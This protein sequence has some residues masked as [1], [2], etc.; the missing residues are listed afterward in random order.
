M[1]LLASSTSFSSCFL[2]ATRSSHWEIFADNWLSWRM[3]KKRC[4]W[5]YWRP[6]PSTH[7]R[8]HNMTG[9]K[10]QRFFGNVVILVIQ[11]YC[12]I[13]SVESKNLLIIDCS[14][15]S[16]SIW[17]LHNANMYTPTEWLLPN[18]TCTHAHTHTHTHTNP[19]TPHIYTH[20]THTHTHTHTHNT[21]THTT[22][23]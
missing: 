18:Y 3:K 17:E 11:K 9:S 23:N 13:E 21:H 16:M 10:G 6:L 14:I 1:Y 2:S 5:L 7:Y 20:H 4:G 15:I 12:A 19:H 22:V 8:S